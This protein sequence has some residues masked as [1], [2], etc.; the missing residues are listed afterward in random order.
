MASTAMG[1]AKDKASGAVNDLKAKLGGNS[2]KVEWNSY[3]YPPCIKV[4]HYDLSELEP[5]QTVLRITKSLW[6]T[7]IAI[8]ILSLFNIV[9]TVI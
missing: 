7:H 6:V 8:F 5:D 9:S 4:M 2:L 3:N 1:M